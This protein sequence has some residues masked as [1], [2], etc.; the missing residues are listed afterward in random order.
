MAYNLNSSGIYAMRSLSLLQISL[1]LTLFPLP[2]C[3]LLPLISGGFIPTTN[4]F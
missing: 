3:G 1:L 4:L 2:F